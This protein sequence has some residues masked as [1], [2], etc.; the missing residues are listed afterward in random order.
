MRAADPLIL[1]APFTVPGAG[2]GA[3]AWGMMLVG[4]RDNAKKRAEKG[5]PGLI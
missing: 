1:R 5:Y 3:G 2:I 4:A